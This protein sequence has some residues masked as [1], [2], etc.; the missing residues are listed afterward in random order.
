M[1]LRSCVSVAVQNSG[2]LI[3]HQMFEFSDLLSVSN[4][5]PAPRKMR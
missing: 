3:T 4:L 2:L 5:S 1:S